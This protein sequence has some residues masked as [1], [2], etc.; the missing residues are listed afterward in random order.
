MLRV[1]PEAV[2]QQEGG[3]MTIAARFFEQF[4]HDGVGS[5]QPKRVHA[6]TL[7]RNFVAS[8]PRTARFTI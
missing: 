2:V 5:A 4:D 1:I 8:R 7:D 3:T 6:G